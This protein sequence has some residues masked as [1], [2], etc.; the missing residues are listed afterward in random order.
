M[1]HCNSCGA[2]CSHCVAA[3]EVTYLR[4]PER[5]RAKVRA[6]LESVGATT[7]ERV[8]K[9]ISSVTQY[10]DATIGRAFRVW[11]NG[12]YGC[13]GKD[14]R[15]FLGILRSV[16][17]AKKVKLESLPPLIEPDPEDVQ[18]EGAGIE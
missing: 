9:V 10:D 15:Y 3:T 2:P 13:E 1:G 8:S 17:I 14:E 16:A 11:E 12:G 4:I 6:M 5:H 7:N 18:E